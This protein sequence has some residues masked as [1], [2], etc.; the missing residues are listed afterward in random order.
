MAF[1]GASALHV[2]VGCQVDVP[3]GFACAFGAGMDT[4]S[5]RPAVLEGASS[6]GAATAGIVSSIPG[7]CSFVAASVGAVAGS[8]AVAAVVVVAARVAGLVHLCLE[9][10]DGGGEGRHLLKH[11]LVL[12]ILGCG[13]G[14]VVDL[15]LLFWG[16]CGDSR[17]VV[18]ETGG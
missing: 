18:A 2:G 13:I 1:V 7:A 9:I 11:L 10:G 8:A 4:I 14:E 6:R 17:S 12:C 16:C 15:L 5:M 3:I